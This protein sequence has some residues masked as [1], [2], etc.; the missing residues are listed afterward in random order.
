M[1]SCLAICILVLIVSLLPTLVAQ[2]EIV[3]AVTGNYQEPSLIV[4]NGYPAMLYLETSTS[5][6]MFVRAL[7]VIGTAW[8]P[9]VVVA[10][11][12]NFYTHR[13]L[14]IVN[15][16]PAV[17]FVKYNSLSDGDLMYVRATDAN[18]ATWGTPV[19][20][21]AT[22][23]V[24]VMWASLAVING[25]PAIAYPV[26]TNGAITYV[27]ATDAN[28]TSWGTPVTVDANGAGDI[29]LTTVNGN[30]A[31]SYAGSVNSRFV[32]A[33]DANGTTWGTPVNVDPWP[34]TTAQG[35]QSLEVVNGNPAMLVYSDGTF[36]TMYTRATDADGTSWS[37]P[38][39]V[40]PSGSYLPSLRIVNGNPAF[41]YIGINGSDQVLTFRRATDA[42]GT[43]WG[44]PVL[45]DTAL[46]NDGIFGISDLTIVNG[47]P[48]VSYIDESGNVKYAR[49]CDADGTL[50]LPSCQ[51]ITL[52]FAAGSSSALEVNGFG[53]LLLVTTSDGNPT[54]EAV[55]VRVSVTGGSTTAPDYSIT[56]T[57]TIP[58]GTANNAR[59]SIASG[60]RVVD[61][62]LVEPDETVDLLLSSAVAPSVQIV[63]GTQDTTIH[64]ILNDDRATSGTNNQ[65]NGE[66]GQITVFDPAISKLGFLRP[67]EVGAQGEVLEWVITVS[68]PS[69]VSGTNV[70]VTDTLNAAM[71]IDRVVAPQGSVSI[72]GQ[73]VT[74]TFA[75]LA[76]QQT[77]QFSIF[78]TVTDGVRFENTACVQTVDISQECV[79]A[80]A[81]SNLPITGESPWWRGIGFVLVF[82]G[83]VLTLLYIVYQRA[84]A[85][86]KRQSE[87]NVR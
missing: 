70:V 79:S 68:N 69:T 11:G 53:N 42:N 86:K 49:A 48:A 46:H 8:G 10:T 50:W 75:V 39:I 54:Y 27:R 66:S 47:N 37:S 76:P 17:S 40:T 59:V 7:D 52:A 65:N 29:S 74:V 51:I 81:V 72:N 61:D 64:T 36:E 3:T 9:P 83:V 4:V 20:V 33:T 57:I 13:S 45:I 12:G 15:G 55:T 24:G 14:Q 78:T 25:N 38:I 44:T 18:G 21:D 63:L 31:I 71:R 35:W 87:S 30:P 19:T 1:R 26:G 84:I 34:A 6:L 43:V 80:L 32:R 67:G 56:G 23:N 22:S 2:A 60:I 5:D 82:C 16:N 85:P 62:T 77:V 58:A 28:G 73:T 41:T